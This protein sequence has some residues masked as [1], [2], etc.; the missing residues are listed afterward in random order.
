MTCILPFALPSMT[1][2]L[3]IIH[4]VRVR[5][6]ID[7]ASQSLLSV[8]SLVWFLLSD[9]QDSLRRSHRERDMVPDQSLD[10]LVAQTIM[11]VAGENLSISYHTGMVRTIPV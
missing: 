6:W 3:Y 11:V 1:F 8:S 9:M 5:L 4:N 2:S 7:E 10:R